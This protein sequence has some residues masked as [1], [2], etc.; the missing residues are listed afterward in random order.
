MSPRKAKETKIVDLSKLTT[1]GSYEHVGQL[2]ADVESTMLGL[3][4]FTENEVH[5]IKIRADRLT[6]KGERVER[7]T[8][9]TADLKTAKQAKIDKLLAEVAKM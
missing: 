5:E 1:R 2:L 6:A 3:G 4:V 8:K 9:V 7:Q